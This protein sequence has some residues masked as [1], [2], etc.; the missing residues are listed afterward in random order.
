MTN[1]I[2]RYRRQAEE[3]YRRLDAVLADDCDDD[4]DDHHQR[5][6]RNRIM[7]THHHHRGPDRSRRQPSPMIRITRDFDA[8]TGPACCGPTPT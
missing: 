5:A 7:T 2:E 1:W 4:S 6:E 3:R 8:T